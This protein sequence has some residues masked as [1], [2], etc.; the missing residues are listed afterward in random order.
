MISKKQLDTVLEERHGAAVQACFSSATVGIAGLGG[1]GSQIAI[2]LARLGVGHLVLVDFDSV[3]LS[4]LNRQH[5]FLRHVGKPKPQALAEQIHEINPYLHCDTYPVRVTSQNACSLFSDCSVICEAFDLA[6][7][8]AMF[9]EAILSG[10]PGITL[11]SGSGMAGTASANLIRTEQ[12]MG[13]LYLCGDGESDL[14]F[15]SL[16]SPRVG[17]CA[18]HQATMVMRLLLGDTFP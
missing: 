10:L 12:P 2:H 1:L 15:G 3:D 4:N 16:M 8:K 5:Y 7:Q 17:V 6:D 18:A 9:V 14:G 13:R 11:V